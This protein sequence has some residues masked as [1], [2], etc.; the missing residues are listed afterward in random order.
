ML[1]KEKEVAAMKKEVLAE[2]VQIEGG[3]VKDPNDSG[4]ETRWGITKKAARKFGYKGAMR[5]LPIWIAY[6]IY[7]KRYLK[8]IRFDE[9]AA[10][11]ELVA[12]ELADTSVNM[13]WRRAGEFLQRSLNVLNR[14]GKDYDDL[15][16][17][18]K[19][20]A[21]TIEALR[22]YLDRRGKEGEAVLYKM[23]NAL[24]GAFYVELA[25]RRSKDEKFVFGW[26]RN[27]VA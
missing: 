18:G 17:D 12:K 14:G 8:K 27:R 1:S 19:I 20:G 10:M 23:L 13:G 25:E 21:K 2:I 3:Y 24:Q 9:I 7:E 26:Y 22:R 5:D 16:V 4:G 11:S 15:V 6:E